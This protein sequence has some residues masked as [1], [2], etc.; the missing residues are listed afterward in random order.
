MVCGCSSHT[1]WRASNFYQAGG[2]RH[3]RRLGRIRRRSDRCIIDLTVPWVSMVDEP[4]KSAVQHVRNFLF[5]SYWPLCRRRYNRVLPSLS[6]R[7]ST[8]SRSSDFGWWRGNHGH[9]RYIVLPRN[10]DMAAVFWYLASY[11]RIVFAATINKSAKRSTTSSL[12]WANM[13]SLNG[14]SAAVSLRILA[15]CAIQWK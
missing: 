8:F 7:R 15:S 5:C 4:L 10:A 9:R 1:L 3:R 13:G 11:C 12:K 2:G 6:K 14:R